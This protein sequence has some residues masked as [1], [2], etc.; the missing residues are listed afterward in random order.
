M[1]NYSQAKCTWKLKYEKFKKLYTAAIISFNILFYFC[2]DLC[3]WVFII[4][5]IFILY[6]LTLGFS[7]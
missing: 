2:A 6:S 1:K 4:Y 3:F 5:V 7:V